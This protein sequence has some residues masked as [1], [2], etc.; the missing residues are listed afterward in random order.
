[1]AALEDSWDAQDS[2]WGCCTQHGCWNPHSSPAPALGACTCQGLRSPKVLGLGGGSAARGDPPG[3]GS[4]R[5][6]GPGMSFGENL[7]NGPIL[8]AGL[9]MGVLVHAP[10]LPPTLVW[11]PPEQSLALWGEIAPSKWKKQMKREMFEAKK[12]CSEKPLLGTAFL[13]RNHFLFAVWGYLE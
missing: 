1:M 6:T 11:L 10:S 2:P 7:V 9:H 8:S 13:S 4:G 12:H 3:T 5:A